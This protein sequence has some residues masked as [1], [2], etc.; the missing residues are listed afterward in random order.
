MQEVFEE[1][2][3]RNEK[4]GKSSSISISSNQ[5]AKISSRYE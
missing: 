1:E 3:K 5:N 4:D 2:E